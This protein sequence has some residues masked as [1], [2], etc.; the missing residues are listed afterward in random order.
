MPDSQEAFAELIAPSID[1]REALETVVKEF[2]GLEALSRRLH[3]LFVDSNQSQ[4]FKILKMIYDGLLRQGE[5][6]AGAD[7]TDEARRLHEALKQNGLDVLG[8]LDTVAPPL[9]DQNRLKPHV[10]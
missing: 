1:P 4:Q 9:P 6:D 7:A 10:N 2:G 5:I 3:T 8:S